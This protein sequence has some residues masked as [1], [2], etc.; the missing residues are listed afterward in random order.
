MT[1]PSISV[2]IPAFNAEKYLGEAL[3]S[4]FAQGYEPLEVLV[5]DD[6]STDGTVAVA[7]GFAGVRVIRR[8]HGGAGAAR[9]AGVAF[10]TGEFIAFLDADDVW[11]DGRLALMT[12]GLKEGIDAVSGWV[13]E[14]GD[15]REDTPA[16][17]AVLPST[18]IVRREWFAR[19]GPF[20]DSLRVGEFIDWW[21]RAREAGLEEAVVSSVV[22]RRRIHQ[23]NTGVTMGRD[24]RVDYTRLL[25]ASLQR[26]RGES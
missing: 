15:S 26:R 16:T 11:T 8:E 18:S 2:V 1:P 6:A 12:P 13:I 19:V 10:A 9:N 23:T 14:F 20:N 24:A 22:A 4:V 3:E 17:Q 7:D 25:R 5:V 21:A